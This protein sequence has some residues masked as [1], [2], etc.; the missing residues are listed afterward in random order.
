MLAVNR[1]TFL[2]DS[3]GKESF[4]LSEVVLED[5][6]KR[7]IFLPPIIHRYITYLMHCVLQHHSTE[8]IKE[9]KIETKIK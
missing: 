6:K 4:E 2:I 7:K 5:K 8:A 1:I 9:K 3:T